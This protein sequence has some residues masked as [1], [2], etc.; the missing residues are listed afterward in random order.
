MTRTVASIAATTVLGAAS[1][2][3]SAVLLAAPASAAVESCEGGVLVVVDF[4]DLGGEVETG[5]AEGDPQSG[6]DALELAGFAPVDGA[7]PGLVCTIDDQ[8][9]PCPTAFEGSYWAYWQVHDGEWVASEV[10]FDEADPTPGGIEGWRYNDGSV[11]PPLPDAA[12]GVGGGATGE[13]TGEGTDEAA[14]DEAATDETGTEDATTDEATTEDTGTDESG[15]G[16]TAGE[17]VTDD[18]SEQDAGGVSPALWVVLGV[19][20]LGIVVG[21]VV[22][23]RRAKEAAQ[24]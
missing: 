3:A 12:A 13:A 23:A 24:K 14:T 11:P 9:D 8:P 20:V 4:T 17:D 1:L 10:G 21:V 19:V 5:C 7:T 22:R 6:R 15:D 18:G 16:T 2:M